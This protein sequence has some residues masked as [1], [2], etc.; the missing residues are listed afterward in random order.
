MNEKPPIKLQTGEKIELIIRRSRASLLA[1]WVGET[2]AI[3][4]FVVLLIGV[5]TI[6]GTSDNLKTFI[7]LIMLA[8]V[9]CAVLSGLVGTFLNFKNKLFITNKRAI[10]QKTPNLLTNEVKVI[11]LNEVEDVSFKKTGIIANIFGY[12][13][14]RL[15]TE[16]DE[17]TYLFP[18]CDTPTDEIEL[19]T[20]LANK[21]PKK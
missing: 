10:Y 6:S 21:A 4:A 13:T 19:I 16:S 11:N 15:S 9:I 20:K 1:V 18:Y 8:L 14:L 3:L 17:T 2:L 5:N 12:G 7:I